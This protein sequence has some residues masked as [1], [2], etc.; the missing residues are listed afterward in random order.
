MSS[1]I[2]SGESLTDRIGDLAD[3]LGTSVPSLLIGTAVAIGLIALAWFALF[4]PDPPAPELTIPYASTP[5]PSPGGGQHGAGGEPSDTASADIADP[6]TGEPVTILVHAA[7]A[8]VHPGVY[9][10]ATE[11]RVSDLLAAAGGPSPEADLDRVNLAAPLADG[12]RIYVPE[13]GE[14]PPPVI[15]GESPTGSSGGGAAPDPGQAVNINT[16]TAIQLEALP[17]VGPAT[18]AAIVEH[19][20]RHGPFASVEDLIEVRGIGEAKLAALRDRVHT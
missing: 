12:S 2:A 11:A 9:S 16:A 1:P 6:A 15:A 3:R 19:R 13:R 10:V 14:D 17:G 5:E 18:A 4:R 20:E 7:G 8:V